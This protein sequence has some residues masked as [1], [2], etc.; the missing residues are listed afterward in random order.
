MALIAVGA[1]H[2]AAARPA[3]SCGGAALL[4]GAQ[5]ICSHVDPKAPAQICTFSWALATTANQVQV[6]SG[7]FLLPPG[8]SNVV[9]NGCGVA[10][11]K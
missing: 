1:S 3:F 2:S 5:L 6:V 10:R 9:R 7:S 4:G 8:A 11:Q